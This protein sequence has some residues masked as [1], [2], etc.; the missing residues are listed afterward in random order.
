MHLFSVWVDGQ[1]DSVHLRSLVGKAAGLFL[2]GLDS[3]CCD[4]ILL[5]GGLGLNRNSIKRRN[6]GKG[7][8]EEG[9]AKKPEKT[10]RESWMSAVSESA[11]SSTKSF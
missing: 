4:L 11:Y 6:V 8:E 2:T 1:R 10:V 3:A 5:P 7:K 9:K